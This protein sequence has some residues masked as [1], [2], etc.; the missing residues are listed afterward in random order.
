MAATVTVDHPIRPDTLEEC[1]FHVALAAD[2]AVHRANNGILDRALEVVLVRRDAPGVRYLAKDDP[3]ALML[4]DS[5]MP[6]D[7]PPLPPGCESMDPGTFEATLDLALVDGERTHEGS[8]RYYVLASFADAWADPRPL[9]VDHRRGPLPSP[10]VPSP[11]P[12]DPSATDVVQ[13]MLMRDG[14]TARFYPTGGVP[15]VAGEIGAANVLERGRLHPRQGHRLEADGGT[16]RGGQ[17]L[18]GHRQ[19]GALAG[20]PARQGLEPR[21]VVAWRAGGKVT[22]GWTCR[23][24]P[25]MLAERSG[26]NR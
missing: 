5:V 26:P 6:P 24:C 12:R 17:R 19:A 20:E 15:R 2:P 8:A 10:R 13:A 25:S 18:G 22:E 11:P 21:T 3:H 16:E 14:V 7:A 23:R 4:P 9:F 1:R